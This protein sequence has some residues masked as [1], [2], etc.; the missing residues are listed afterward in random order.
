MASLIMECM[1]LDMIARDQSSWCTVKDGN[2]ARV[3]DEAVGGDAVVLGEVIM[4]KRL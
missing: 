3:G 4:A 1:S 2:G